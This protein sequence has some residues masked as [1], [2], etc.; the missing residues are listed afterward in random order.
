MGIKEMIMTD[1][2]KLEAAG[3]VLR[4]I[5]VGFIETLK[6][7][8]DPVTLENRP[9]SSEEEVVAKS[10]YNTNIALFNLAI[11]TIQDLYEDDE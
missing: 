6:V 5:V 1:D 8:T 4:A 3:P 2:T 10:Y 9:L 11:D 7:A